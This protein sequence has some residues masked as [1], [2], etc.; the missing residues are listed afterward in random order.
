MH[1]HM[2]IANTYTLTHSHYTNIAHLSRDEINI[3]ADKNVTRS[4]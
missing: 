3:S 2:Y 4:A 1:T